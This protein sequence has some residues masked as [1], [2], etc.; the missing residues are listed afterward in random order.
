MNDLAN[1]AGDG[2]ARRPRSRN[3]MLDVADLKGVVRKLAEKFSPFAD[4][5]E[6]LGKQFSQW[7]EK[8]MP[9]C[10]DIEGYICRGKVVE[11]G[12]RP[13][14]QKPCLTVDQQKVAKGRP[15]G[16]LLRGRAR[17]PC[18]KFLGHG[19]RARPIDTIPVGGP[20]ATLSRSPVRHG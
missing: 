8:R 14:T 16:L 1:F 2:A 19:I 12:P 15:G 9:Q 7:T 6:A 5:T 20:F 11:E 17:I 18:P 4:F 10:E 13:S 3:A